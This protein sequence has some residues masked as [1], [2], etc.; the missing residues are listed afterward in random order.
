[1]ASEL[2]AFIAEYRAFVYAILTRHLNFSAND[3]DEVFQRFMIRIWEDNCRRLHGWNGRGS[4]R[5]YIGTIVRNLA[6]DYRRECA[7]NQEIERTGVAAE[8]A[9][10]DERIPAVEAAMLRL[11]ARDRELLHRRYNLEQSYKE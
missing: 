8:A 4:F 10:A 11:P 5:A 2:E 7:N 6:H 1:M 9:P 3:A